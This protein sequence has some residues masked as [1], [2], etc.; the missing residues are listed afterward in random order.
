MSTGCSLFDTAIGPCGVAW[1]ATGITAIQLP[2]ESS[3]A[4]LARTVKRSG[5]AVKDPPAWVSAATAKIAKLVAGAPETLEEVPLDFGKTT[6]FRRKVYDAAR[7]VRPGETVTY[8]DLASAVGSSGASR[9]VGMAMAKN[10]IPLVVPCHR[11][12]GAGGAATGFSAFGG[13]QTKALLLAAEGALKAIKVAP[14]A[15]TIG[16]EGFDESEVRA[17]LTRKDKTLGKWIEEIGPFVMTPD[18]A[19]S[20]YAALARSIVSQ[21]LHT[22]AARTIFGRLQAHGVGGAV[23]SPEA[24]LALDDATMRAVGLS[25]SKT[26]GLRDLAQKTIDGVV[27]DS[28]ALEAMSDQEII[29]R[30]TQVRG[31][32]RWT[33]EMMLMFRMG[34]PDVLPVD[35][36]GVR[37]GFQLA[38]KLKDMP[39]PK[40]LVA[41]AERWRPWRSA[42]SWYLWRVVD[43]VTAKS[44]TP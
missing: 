41:R 3:E 26:A 27:P 38:F 39:S 28:A 35:D 34:R 13:V 1:S 17:H 44:K 23:P 9:A 40:D 32:G 42:A 12:L 4:T 24:L 37:K 8:G 18:G 15:K 14:V 30:L 11:V 22:S 21:Q 20:P 6:E 43:R 36:F 25:G 7:R 16:G 2:E 5:A 29:D 33:V 19:Q 31:I 10:P